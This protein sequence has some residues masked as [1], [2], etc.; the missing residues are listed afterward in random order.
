MNTANT[1]KTGASE[2]TYKAICKEGNYKGNTKI[3]EVKAY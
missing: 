3:S 1:Q 2:L